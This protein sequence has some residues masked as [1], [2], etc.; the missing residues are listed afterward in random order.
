M[1][2]AELILH[3]LAEAKCS[4]AAIIV[5]ICGRAGSGKTMLSDK[6]SAILGES[7]IKSVAYSGDWRFIR[8]SRTRKK[9]LQEKW[10]AGIDAYMYAINQ[11]T[12]W[13]FE[14]I[15]MDLEKLAAGEPLTIS[16][17]YNRLSGNMDLEIHIP[18]IPNGVILYE[19]SI[20]GG[21]EL[22]E[23][24]DPVILV[25]TPDSLCFTRLLQKDAGRRT[26][27]EI[28][29]R[30]LITTYSE[31]I[32]FHMLL[33]HFSAKTL[34]C[35]SDG[36][37]GNY[38]E[39]CEV[40]HIPVPISGHGAMLPYKGTI[41][42]DLDG[43]LIKHVPVPSENGEEISV[44]PGSKEKLREFRDK[45]YYLI[46]TTSRI[47]A[48]VFPILDKL[49][50]DGLDFDQIICDLPVGPRFLINDSKVDECRAYA[51]DLR[52]DQG[53]ADINIP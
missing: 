30:Y 33:D 12:W 1:E 47:Y 36:S 2:I 23:Q 21:V 14:Q 20:L 15:Q 16:A 27:P 31:N 6:I 11:Y 17:G 44:L 5:G 52:R 13:N 45:G 3:K 42:C 8:D 50:N 49:K 28:A 9:W 34:I 25:N 10:K 48:K 41:F 29:C 32:F 24:I 26:L 4:R 19:N 46:L 7:G 35:D 39:I 18:E 43:T 40:A 37:F 22:L 53:I 38:S 51:F